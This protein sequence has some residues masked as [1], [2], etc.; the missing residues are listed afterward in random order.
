MKENPATHTRTRAHIH[1]QRHVCMHV[2]A[3]RAPFV[4]R[5]AVLPSSGWP[6]LAPIAAPRSRLVPRTLAEAFKGH[7]LPRWSFWPHFLSQSGPPLSMP[8]DE[9]PTDAGCHLHMG[10]VLRSS[11]TDPVAL[12][13]NNSNHTIFEVIWSFKVDKAQQ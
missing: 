1:T 5:P 2:G 8:T 6:H 13:H 4:S 10:P 3:A 9:G 12:F 11:G 7:T